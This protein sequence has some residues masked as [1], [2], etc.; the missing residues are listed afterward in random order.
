ML[1]PPSSLSISYACLWPSLLLSLSYLF[2][3]CRHSLASS[4]PS[5][6]PLLSNH[7]LFDS[8]LSLAHLLSALC[9][10]PTPLTL[11]LCAGCPPA[12][13]FLSLLLCLTPSSGW[14][15]QTGRTW[16]DG[17]GMEQEDRQAGQEEKEGK[18][19]TGRIHSSFCT[20]A[21]SLIMSA[22]WACAPAVPAM[23]LST[24]THFLCVSVFFLLASCGWRG[25]ALQQTGRRPPLV[26]SLDKMCV[27]FLHSLGVR[28]S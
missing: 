15:G 20:C 5:F 23:S 8:L 19:Q 22:A 9:S 6:L 7:L 2:F 21:F 3:S 16:K 13:T 17:T 12:L 26:Y 27:F 28:C 24:L 4:S 18:G 1:L 14:A 10:S 11:S 25:E